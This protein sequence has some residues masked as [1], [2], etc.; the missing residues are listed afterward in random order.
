MSCHPTELDN[1]ERDAES[2]PTELHQT[3]EALREEIM[4]QVTSGE[5]DRALELSDQALDLATRTEDPHLIDSALCNR[6]GLLVARGEG[7]DVAGELRRILMRSPESVVRFQAAYAL[8]MFHEQDEDL[9]KSRFYSQTALRYAEL[10]G[11]PASLAIAHNRVANLNLLASYFEPALES[12][13]KAL[14][15]QGTEPSLETAKI[16]SNTGYCQAV[17]GELGAA[18]GS[19]T[20]SL[21]MLR[22]IRAEQWLHRPMLGMSY[23][24]L[25]AGRYDRAASYALKALENAET[26]GPYHDTHV[27]N[28]LYLLG[29]AEKLRGEEAAAYECFTHLQQRFYPDQPAIVD[30]LLAT[31]IR[32]LI[33][34]MA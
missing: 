29:E 4:A 33:N 26:G 22:R 25:E 10:H 5:L 30:V 20:R 31:D 16:L 7:R 3:Y 8:C 17:L 24:Y 14:E 6:A 11:D 32:K 19:L 1:N 27:K 34:L 21:R 12:Y 23:T 9:E 15:I 13:L 18:F 28:A 2:H